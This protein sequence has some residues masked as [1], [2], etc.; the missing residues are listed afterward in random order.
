[1]DFQSSGDEHGQHE[2]DHRHRHRHRGGQAHP[3]TLDRIGDGHR[4]RVL[5][6]TATGEIRR[7]LMDMGFIRGATGRTLRVA[8]LRD[9]IELEM[10]EYKV[11]LRRAEARHIVIEEI[12]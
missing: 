4:F 3:L 7:R 10:L 2:A 6:L 8:L 5:Q 11:S 12:E 1:M 9:P